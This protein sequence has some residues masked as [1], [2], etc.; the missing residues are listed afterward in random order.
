MQK[1]GRDRDKQSSKRKTTTNYFQYV[2]ETQN[3]QKLQ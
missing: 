2:N 3:E 1:L